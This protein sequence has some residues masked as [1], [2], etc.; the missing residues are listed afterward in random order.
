MTTADTALDVAIGAA[1]AAGLLLLFTGYL[2]IQV[3]RMRRAQ[4]DRSETRPDAPPFSSI[5]SRASMK[6]DLIA[7]T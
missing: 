5:V 6:P 1:G 3:R 2:W 4:K 7:L